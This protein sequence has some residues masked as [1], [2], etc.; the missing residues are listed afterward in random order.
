VPETDDGLLAWDVVEARL[1]DSVQYWMATSRPDGRPHVVPRWGV[2]LDRRLYY[3]GSPETRHARNLAANPACAL[4]LE[5]G[6]QAVIV[7]GRSD[8]S[9]PVAGALA[10]RIAAEFRRKY[11]DLGYAPEP[12]AWS[13]DHAG[14]LCVFTPAR[15]L[16]WTSF[17][18]DMTRFRF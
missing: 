14:G 6:W 2:W 16:A 4:H 9:D 11:A 15:A 8:R 17:P 18:T 13:G 7:D 5:D 10:E 1:V 3:D 12:D